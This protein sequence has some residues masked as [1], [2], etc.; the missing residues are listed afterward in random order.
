MAG[1][2]FRIRFEFVVSADAASSLYLVWFDSIFE[3]ESRYVRIYTASGIEPR[4]LRLKLSEP[5]GRDAL[6]LIGSDFHCV[7]RRARRHFQHLHFI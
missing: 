7:L 5:D 3:I 2:S 1:N 6:S 4:A